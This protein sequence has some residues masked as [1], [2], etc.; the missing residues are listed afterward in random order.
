MKLQ[1]QHKTY[2]MFY[3]ICLSLIVRVCYKE[4]ETCAVGL[5]NIVFYCI[6]CYNVSSR[7]FDKLNILN[8]KRTI[9]SIE[10]AFGEREK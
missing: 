1:K 2:L 10:G 8:K 3:Y 7:I 4:F 6:K 5:Y 9:T